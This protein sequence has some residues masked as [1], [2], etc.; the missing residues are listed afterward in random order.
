MVIYLGADHRGFPLKETIKKFLKNGGYEI[1]DCGNTAVD[2][3]D[4]FPDF[5]G[6]V[7]RKVSAAPDASRGVLVCGSAA[8][9]DIVANKFPGIRS[10]VGISPDQVYEAR[11]DNDANVLSIAS[12]FTSEDDVK[13]MLQLFLGTPFER[14]EKRLRRVAKIARLED[15]LIR[16]S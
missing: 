9:V 1:I 7:G 4:D 13:R 12:D 5:A 14:S 2:P 10:I 15:E 16:R 11:R 3:N 8:G 6:A